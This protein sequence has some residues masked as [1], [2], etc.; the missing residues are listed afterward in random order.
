M[1]YKITMSLEQL[2]A[3]TVDVITLKNKDFKSAKYVNLV[4]CNIEKHGMAWV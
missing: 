1:A 3:C 4:V 2:D